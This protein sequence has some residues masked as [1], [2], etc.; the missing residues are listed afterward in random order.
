MLLGYAA[1]ALFVDAA[2]PL[3]VKLGAGAM[4][5]GTLVLAAYVARIRARAMGRD[6][7]EEIDR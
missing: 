1:Y 6:P 7:Y 3:P 5:A 4:G 2:V